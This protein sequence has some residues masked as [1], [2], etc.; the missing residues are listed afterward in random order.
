MIKRVSK[1]SVDIDNGYTVVEMFDH[2]N[3]ILESTTSRFDE[4]T[5]GTY[6]P[7]MTNMSLSRY[8]DTILLADEMNKCP[9]V[10]KE[11]HYDFL[12]HSVHKMKRRFSAWSK[13]N[14]ADHDIIE[15]LMDRY[16]INEKRAH[17]YLELLTEKEITEIENVLKTK[18]GR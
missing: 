11:M 5:Q 1:K 2:I 8:M 15:Y 14:N 3:D 16:D 9:N 13:K 12:F 6:D 4:Y 18:H 10:T 17:R 7:F